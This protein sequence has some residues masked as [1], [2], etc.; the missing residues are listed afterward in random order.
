MKPTQLTLLPD[1]LPDN[2]PPEPAVRRPSVPVCK[3]VGGRWCWKRF[4]E[5][6]WE[7][8]PDLERALLAAQRRK[9]A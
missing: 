4:G 3:Y 5:D 1:I 9:A 2:E 8:E 7:W 6:V